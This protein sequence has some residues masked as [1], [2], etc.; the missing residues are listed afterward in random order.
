MPTRRRETSGYVVLLNSTH[1][2]DAMRRISQLAVRYL[3][4]DV[5]PPAKTE[6]DGP[7]GDPSQLR[8]LLPPGQP[9]QPGVRLHGVAASAASLSR[10][11]AIACRPGRCSAAT[12]STRAGRGQRC[13]VS[14]PTR[15]RRACSPSD[16]SGTMVLTGGIALR[17]AASRDGASK[18]VRWPVLDLGRS[19]AHAAA[20]DDSVDRSRAP[21]RAAGGLLVAEAAGCS[22]AASDSCCR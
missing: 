22:A 16:E 14:K 19:R 20:D 7:R 21:A 1:S 8:G 3:K 6:A 4:A 12:S 15:S 17:R 2:G 11:T 9:S 13:S 18:V 5:D 10:S